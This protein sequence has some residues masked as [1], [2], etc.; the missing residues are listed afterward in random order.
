M[1]TPEWANREMEIIQSP[2]I[3]ILGLSTPDEFHGA[4]Q[5]ESVA[6]GFLNRFLVLDFNLRAAD[7]APQLEPGR[8]PERLAA[9]LRALYLWSGPQNSLADRQS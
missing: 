4:L 7:V 6:N 8:V 3:S 2:A 5:G 9:A 1:A